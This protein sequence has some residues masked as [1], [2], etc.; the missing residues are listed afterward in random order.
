MPGRSFLLL[1]FLSVT[2]FADPLPVKEVAPGIYVHQGVHEE[3]NEH[4]HGDICNIGFI[5]G[6]HSVAVIDTSG[7]FRIGQKLHEAIRKVTN[8]PISHVINT[9]VHPDHIF[10]NAAFVEDHPMFVG[11]AKLADAMELRKDA[12]LKNNQEIL[13]ADFAGSEI[14]KPAIGVKDSME[15]DLGGRI[16]QLKAWPTAHTN[17]D[18]TVFDTSTSTLWTGDLLFVERTP[19]MDGDT[20]NWLT[21][22]PLIKAIPARRA[23]PGHGPVVEQWQQAID[24]Q[25]HYFDVLLTDIRTAIKRGESME[26]TMG[27]AADSEKD[28][29]ILFSSVNRRNINLLYP[30][31]EWE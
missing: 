9:H 12:Y 13:G 30:Q 2:A 5:V 25:Q 23:I 18:L 22:L 17:T 16:L 29:W 11:H 6:Q 20:R 3:L 8:L 24:R 26:N 4:Y 1:C 27:H 31:L 14:V 28:H 15:I 21:V 19:A 7:S 10:G